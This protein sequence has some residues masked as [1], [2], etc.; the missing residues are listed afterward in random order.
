MSKKAIAG[1]LLFALLSILAY[2][3]WERMAARP[4]TA[5]GAG[6]RK[7]L[8]DGRPLYTDGEC[9]SGSRQQAITG[10][11]V[12]IVKGQAPATTGQAAS[13]VRPTDVRDLLVTRDGVDIKEK[14][15]DQVIGQ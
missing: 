6:L 7:C 1:A 2:V 11:T 12:T 4:T 8:V 14:R 15:M 5:Q 13:S 9:P 3:G 10:G